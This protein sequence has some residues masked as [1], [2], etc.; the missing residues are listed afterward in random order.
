MQLVT[1]S[2]LPQL[3]FSSR[4][5]EGLMRVKMIFVPFRYRFSTRTDYRKFL[6]KLWRDVFRFSILLCCAASLSVFAHSVVYILPWL[7]FVE[8]LET[9]L[10]FITR[11]TRN[12]T[13]IKFKIARKS[14]VRPPI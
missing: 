8:S 10:V 9:S 14:G 11:T 4:N 12:F 6:K 3:A 13:E 1:A 5:S 7:Q 2:S